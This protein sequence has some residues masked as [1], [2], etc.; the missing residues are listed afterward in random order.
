MLLKMLPYI[1][2]SNNIMLKHLK[3]IEAVKQNLK[4]N[5]SQ[6]NLFVQEFVLTLLLCGYQ[7]TLWCLCIREFFVIYPLNYKGTIG[8]IINESSLGYRVQRA[9]FVP[10][11]N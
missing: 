11:N 1:K 8:N 4:R 9:F 3:E 5:P 7:K 10:K 6:V 2:Q